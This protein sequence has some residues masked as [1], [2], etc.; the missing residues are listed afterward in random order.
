M[1]CAHS[2]PPSVVASRTTSARKIGARTPRM[3]AAN[4]SATPATARIGRQNARRKR[5]WAKTVIGAHPIQR[6]PMWSRRSRLRDRARGRA[7]HRERHAVADYTDLLGDRERPAPQREERAAEPGPA[8]ASRHGAGRAPVTLPGSSESSWRLQAWPWDHRPGCRRALH[9]GRC[10]LAIRLEEERPHRRHVPSAEAHGPREPRQQHEG[11]AEED[12]GL[13]RA[14]RPPNIAV[15]AQVLPGVA[16][17][18]DAGAP[19]SSAA[20][21]RH[22]E[23]GHSVPRQRGA[24]R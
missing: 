19:R 3:T 11:P 6:V 1:T 23:A 2:A 5:R 24:S 7:A 13:W 9:P 4:T 20:P 10:R 16:W 17:F 22:G 18:A 15:D 14:P 12:D 8:G 21:R